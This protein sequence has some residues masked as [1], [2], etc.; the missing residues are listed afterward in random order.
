M[1][2]L[3][4]GVVVLA[5]AMAL[6]VIDSQVID[7]G[8]A[9]VIGAD[10]IADGAAL[11]EGHFA[12]SRGSAGTSTGRSTTW[13]ISRSSRS[14]AG[15]ASGTTSRPRTPRRSASICS[16]VVGLVALGRRLRVGEEGRALGWALGFAW[17]ACPWTL[18]VMNANAN[19]ALVA[20][21]SIEPCSRCA[22]R[23]PAAG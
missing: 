4:V 10:R 11:Y 9:G 6:N 21:L 18:Y 13:P 23:P 12:D 2:W 17:L 16:G 3:A 8:V 14:S 19:D 15:T 5:A 20:M 7:I 22:R 1:R